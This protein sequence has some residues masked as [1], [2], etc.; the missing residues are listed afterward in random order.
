MFEVRLFPG[1]P[2]GRWARLGP[3]T[4]AVEQSVEPDDPEGFAALI[5]HLLL[6]CDGTTVGPGRARDLAVSDNDR[7]AAKIYCHEYG[8]RVESDLR[9]RQCGKGFKM[10]FILEP[11]IRQASQI[12]AAGVEGPDD[13][14]DFRLR[15][16]PRFR[17]PTLRDQLAVRGLD[18]DGARMELLR[19]CVHEDLKDEEEI[20]AVEAAMEAVGPIISGPVTMSCPHCKFIEDTVEFSM[21]RFLLEALA[22]ER[23][24]LQYEVHYLARAYRW[25]R[26]EILA[27]STSDRRVYARMV[28]AERASR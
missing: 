27:M 14:G 7:I 23:R 6:E 10:S 12:A 3:I 17:L 18:A 9:C 21:Q 20:A 11:L 5:D 4:G 25:S 2:G 19:H 22:F 15:N 28:L 16:G 8:D 26:G 1:L 13:S 24:F